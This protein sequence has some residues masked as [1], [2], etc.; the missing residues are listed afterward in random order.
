M[1]PLSYDV[2]SYCIIVAISDGDKEKMKLDSTNL[3]SWLQSVA[4]FCAL[5]FKKYPIELIAMI[6]YVINQLKRRRSH[7][8]L[9]LQEIVQKMCGIEVLSEVNDL[10][11]EAMAGGDILRQEAGYFNPIRNIKKCA[12][13]LKEALADHGL[14]LPLCILLSQQRDYIVFADQA[15]RAEAAGGGGGG[16]GGASINK[17]H[18]KLTGCLYDQCQDSLVQFS[19]FL[20]STLTT[21]EYIH[22]FPTIDVLVN[23]YHVSPDVA[24]FLSRPMYA[25]HINSKYDELRRVDRG[26]NNTSSNS[27]S[28]S[29]NKANKTLRYL[30]AIDVVMQPVIDLARTLHPA[31]IWEDMSALFYTTFWTLSMNDLYVPGHAYEKQRVALKHKLSSLDDNVELTSTKK[32]KEKEKLNIMLD[33]LAEEEAK[34]RDHV[35]QVKAR[36]D[37]EKEHWFPLKSRTKNE[38]ITVFLQYC[39]FSRCLFTQIDA[40]YCAKFVQIIHSLKTPNFSTIICYDRIFSDISYSIASLTDNEARRYGRFLLGLLETVMSWHTDPTTFDAECAAHPGFLTVFRNA[41]GTATA[42]ANGNANTSANTSQASS[43]SSS[44]G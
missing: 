29:S 42:T 16:G 34:Q 37:K 13:R 41:L 12:N 5:T 24:F 11:L 31:K 18:M 22:I 30:E 39:I 26:T 3:S 1:T 10:Q 35:A 9:I 25:H 21:D 38:T 36:L 17:R 27:N 43:T 19:Q 23:D 40:Y 6:Q 8:L 2:L 7:D 44:S 15:E 32:K 33:K 4:T 28:S 20:S 14:I